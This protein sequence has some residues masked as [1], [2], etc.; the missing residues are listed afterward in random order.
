MRSVLN[1][2]DSALELRCSSPSSSFAVND[3]RDLSRQPRPLMVE[4][5]VREQRQQQQAEQIQGNGVS[6]DIGTPCRHPPYSVVSVNN[7]CTA[8]TTTT[9]TTT[10]SGSLSL[11]EIQ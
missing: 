11:A 5:Y 8:T 1:V 10:R 9:T 4:E 2:I 3:P 6:S 7:S